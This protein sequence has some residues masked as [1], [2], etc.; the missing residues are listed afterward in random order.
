MRDGAGRNRKGN[1]GNLLALTPAQHDALR[2]HAK[3]R[4][5]RGTEEQDFQIGL[6]KGLRTILYPWTVVLHVPNGGKR[7]K[8]EAGILKAMGVLAGAPDLLMFHCGRAYAF[9]L[10]ADDGSLSKAQKETHALL[11][12]AGVP[13]S[14][15]RTLDEV[16]ERLKFWNIPT[17]LK[18]VR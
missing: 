7:G 2:G 9:E 16:L 1:L 5:R 13:V 15:C 17:K 14:V 11:E 8:A 12:A 3:P 18:E 10:K 6:V 4:K